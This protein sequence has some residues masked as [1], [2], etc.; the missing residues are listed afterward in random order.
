MVVAQWIE[1]WRLKPAT[2]V[3]FPAAYRFFCT[4]PFKPVLVSTP[5][6]MDPG[7]IPGSLWCLQKSKDILTEGGMVC[8]DPRISMVSDGSKDTTLTEGG[9]ACV[10]PRISIVSDR[11]EDTLTESGMA[12]V[13]PRISTVSDGSKATLTEGGMVYVDLWTFQGYP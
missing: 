6:C 2:W 7:T 13:D 5:H 9:M 11:S 10:D 3:Q 8:V 4:F 1:H 12:Y